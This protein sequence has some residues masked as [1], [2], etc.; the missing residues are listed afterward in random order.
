MCSYVN[1]N[2]K[3][4]INTGHTLLFKP[5]TVYRVQW[6]SP[7]PTCP[8]QNTNH[9]DNRITFSQTVRHLNLCYRY[10][11]LL[12]FQELPCANLLLPLI[13]YWSHQ[14]KHSLSIWVAMVYLLLSSV[15]CMV[16]EF[17]T[18]GQIQ[19]LIVY[20]TFREIPT[21]KFQLVN[22]VLQDWEIVAV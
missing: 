17:F 9:P 8:K 22:I 13:T 18:R 16:Q 5:E 10:L 2:F 15:S 11:C 7:Q 3:F 12:V 19:L 1:T 4:N 14:P 20:I 21:T 6:S